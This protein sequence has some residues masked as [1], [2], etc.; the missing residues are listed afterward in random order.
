MLN[1]VEAYS[2]NEKAEVRKVIKVKGI[3]KTFGEKEILKGID[4]TINKGEVVV[5]IGPSGSGKSTLLRT[6]NILET[7]TSGDVFLE[8]ESIL[9][10]NI[11]KGRKARSP[12]EISRFR[13]D[14]GMVAQGFNL[15]PHKTVIENIIEGPIRVRKMN[16]EEAITNGKR[17]LDKIGLVD[18]HDQYPQALS[19]G[20][21]QRVAIARALAMN[22]KLLLFDEPT[23]ALDPELVG[24]VLAV[25]K[26]LAIEGMTMVVVTHEMAFARDVGDRIIF[27]D[28]GVIIHEALSN[29]FFSKNNQNERVRKFL[30]NMNNY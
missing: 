28:E 2:P 19:G 1:V 7:P 13:Q 16:K 5:I 15:F 11:S 21:Q 12:K 29:D 25:I 4:L 3:R 20:Q 9:Y 10:K 17:L 8:D 6:M 22:P 23:S 24:E 30:N 14:I 27:M 18:K 26:E